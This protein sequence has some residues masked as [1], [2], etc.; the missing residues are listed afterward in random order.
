MISVVILHR[1]I[2]FIQKAK[3]NLKQTIGVEYELIIIDNKNNDFNI[4]NGYNLGVRKSKFP[5][6]CFMHEDLL[7]HTDDW[8]KRV[9]SHFENSDL[10]LLGVVGGTAMPRV[11]A[12][13]WTKHPL[14]VH[15]VNLIQHWTRQ[16][17]PIGGYRQEIPG[18]RKTRDYNNPTNKKLNEGIAVDGLWF[19]VRKELFD[20]VKF[21]QETYAGFHFYD[22]DICFQVLARGYKVMFASDILVEHFSEGHLSKDWFESALIFNK[23]WRHDLPKFINKVDAKK[24][25]E[26]EVKALLSFAYWMRSAGIPDGKIKKTIS[27]YIFSVWSFS[28]AESFLLLFW[29]ILG[30]KMARYPYR[31]ITT[32][33]SF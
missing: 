30:Y 33:K 18:T 12:T 17:P 15:Y 21:D 8:G 1:N 3:T 23:K 25:K 9:L 7:F 24:Y 13:W 27:E 19:C 14:N 5:I 28:A 4:F 16:E 11:P 6:I 2:D 22:V 26:D 29:S 20:R 10:G 32:F 31:L